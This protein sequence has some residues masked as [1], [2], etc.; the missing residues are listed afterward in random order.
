MP[1][2]SLRAY[3]ARAIVGAIADAA[4]RWSDADF[5]P[6]VR[7]T[8]AIEA[9][10]GYTTPVVEYALDRLFFSLRR[11][12]LTAAIVDELGSLDALDGF[13]TRAGRPAAFARGVARVVV[14]SSDT[15]IGVALPAALFALCAKCDV[16]VKDRS[17]ALVAA[18][19]ET[20]VEELP[21]FATA[22]RAQTW[23]GGNDAD[24]P[25]LLAAA[26][27]VVAFGGDDALRAIRGRCAADAR[28][29]AFGHRV[30]V[31]YL[32]RAALQS[33]QRASI[34]D[35]IAADTLLYDGDG[36]LSL[37]TL[38]VERSDDGDSADDDRAFARDLAEAFA[39]TEIE[40][41]GG[42]LDAA[43]AASVAAY[44]N[45]GAFRAANTPGARLT[46]LASATL[47]FDPPRE[48]PLPLLPRVL[49]IYTVNDTA[50][51]LSF[52]R[53]HRLP[54]QALGVADPGAADIAQLAED[55]GA[56]RIARFGLMQA[57]PL[58]GHHGGAPRISDVI[59]WIDAE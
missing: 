11:E 31:G 51:V 46:S 36:C 52:A 55:I 39:R 50:D 37:H 56:V 43:S 45:L 21:E 28:F 25:A 3:S 4:E 57:P 38:F 10:L 54:I 59:R 13:V 40:F 16:V 7:A 58:A 32:T 49:P 47:A 19:F 44:R 6:R 15:T 8:A 34:L 48:A 2:P 41:P 18:F 24:E 35:G 9:R 12:S 53:A 20:L 42:R 5:P 23:H 17:D 29:V 22:A 27:V 33:A 26:D 14:V 1:K 30:S